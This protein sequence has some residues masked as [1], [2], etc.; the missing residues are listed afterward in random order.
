MVSRSTVARRL[1]VA[2][3]ILF[4]VESASANVRET[5]ADAYRK[6][7]EGDVSGAIAG[8][9][10]AFRQDPS[11]D[12]VYSFVQEVSYAGLLRMVRSDDK[13][14]SGAALKLLSKVKEVQ[15]Q[16]SSSVDDMQAAID[17]VFRTTDRTERLVL[18]GNAARTYRRNLVPLLIPY[19]A[20]PDL[21]RR[22][23]AINWIGHTIGVDALPVLHAARQHPDETVRTNVAKLLGAGPLRDRSSLATLKAMAEA[24]ASANVR[25]AADRAFESVHADR[26]S[27]A[28]VRSAK[29]YF[30]QNA[31]GYYLRPHK[32]IFDRGYYEPTVYRLEGDRVVSETVARFQVSERMAQADLEAAIELDSGY[33]PAYVLGVCNDAA[34]VVEYDQNVAFYRERGDDAMQALLASQAGYVDSV[35]RL[36]LVQATSAEL[37]RAL[38]QALDDKRSEVAVKVIQTIRETR[39]PGDVPDVLLDALEDPNSR[40]VRIA[41]AVA[42]SER[43]PGD[44]FTAGDNVASVLAEA[45]LSSGVRVVQ[46]V[47]GDRQTANRFAELLRGLNMESYSPLKTIEAAYS[48][49]VESPPDAILIDENVSIEQR[50]ASTAPINHFV[51]QLRKNYRTANVPVVVVVPSTRLRA[52]EELYASDERKVLVISDSIDGL[53]LKNQVFDPL[54]AGA[55]DAKTQATALAAGAAEALASLAE[56]SCGIDVSGTGSLLVRVLENRPD[57]VRLP[58]I[59]ALGLIGERAAAGPLATTFQNADNADEIRAAAMT[60]IGDILHRGGAASDA[61]LSVIE[62]GMASDNLTL[63]RPSW[64]AFSGAQAPGESRLAALRANPAAAAEGGDA[65]PVSGDDDDDAGLDDDDDDDMGLDDDDDD[66]LSLD[67][68]DDDDLSLD[69]DDDDDLGLDDDDDDGLDLDDDDDDGLDF[70]DDDDF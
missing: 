15:T 69:D 39:R 25:A 46:R 30:L 3:C 60:A 63:R 50:P 36:R 12:V 65:A 48:S 5:L 64:Y 22:S 20:D 31:Y 9:E 27:G 56:R 42:I 58:S 45:A 24:D 1:L 29:Q 17:E 28:P 54:F 6:Y 62:E 37:Y 26:A 10:D 53:G 16:K 66:D 57:S 55:D 41:A 44:E 68:D 32:N 23:T 70:D 7:Q 67:D 8:F 43:N 19:L 34:Q 59:R 4:A 33:A 47:I 52:A 35:L 18:T 40:L 49:I 13:R 51:S 61:L 38:G 11:N 14:L 2:C 21:E